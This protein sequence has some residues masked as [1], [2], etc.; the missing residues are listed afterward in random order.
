MTGH[1]VR[2][3]LTA[4]TAGVVNAGHPLPLRLRNGRVQ[5]VGLDVEPPFGVVPGRSFPVQRLPLEP[6]DRIVFLT[7]GMLERN[8]AVLDVAAALRDTTDLHPREVVQELGAAVLRATGGDLGDDATMLCLDWYGGP[9]RSSGSV[10]GADAGLASVARPP[11][12]P[13]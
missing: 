4:G 5:E 13:A 6:G 10:R 8:A 7:D 9:P 1:V 2:V 11:S 3:D 12:R